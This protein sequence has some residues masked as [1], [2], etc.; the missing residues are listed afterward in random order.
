MQIWQTLNI[1]LSCSSKFIIQCFKMV[2]FLCFYVLVYFFFLFNK[3]NWSE[4]IRCSIS[5]STRIWE[6]DS[7][8]CCLIVSCFWKVTFFSHLYFLAVFYIQ[9]KKKN[10]LQA[11]PFRDVSLWLMYTLLSIFEFCICCSRIL[12]NKLFHEPILVWHN[13]WMH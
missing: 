2:F 9:K 10:H 3:F 6:Y 7:K 12:V 1:L 8:L 11:N 4:D 5:H 13:I